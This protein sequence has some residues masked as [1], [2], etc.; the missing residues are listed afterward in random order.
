MGERPTA[1]DLIEALAKSADCTW[2]FFFAC[3]DHG[4]SRRRGYDEPRVSQIKFA[5][6]RQEGI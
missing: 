2:F 6:G 1:T 5:I 3:V 4:V